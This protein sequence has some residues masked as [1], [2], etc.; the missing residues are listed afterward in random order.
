M[1]YNDEGNATSD[2]QPTYSQEI[3]VMNRPDGLYIR[4]HFTGLSDVRYEIAWPK[5]STKRSC[6][7]ND[8]IE[9]SRLNDNITAFVEGESDKQSI[10][11][12]IPKDK[13]MAHSALFENVF[14]K[15]DQSVV[16]S[17]LLHVTDEMGVGGSWVTGLEHIGMKKMDLVDYS[18]YMGNGILTDL[19][20]YEKELPVLYSGENLSVLGPNAALN[21]A[22]FKEADAALNSIDA[23][24]STIVIADNTN[25][26]NSGRFIVSELGETK[27]IADVFL[28]NSMH[29]QFSLSKEEPL[30]AEI[31]ASLLSH[32]AVGSEKSRKIVE[33]LNHELTSSELEEV[34]EMLHNQNGQTIDASFLD[35]VIGDVTGFKTTFISKNNDAEIDFYPFLLEDPREVMI[36]DKAISGASPIIK[37]GKPLYPATKIMQELGYKI[38]STNQSLYIE[39]TLRNFR[40]PLNELFYVYNER[41]YNLNSM[42]FERIGD[43]FYFEE[44]IFIRIFLVEVNK[45][46]EIIEVVPIAQ[47]TEVGGE[48]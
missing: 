13:A 45:T 29:A 2:V 8:G 7:L 12:V 48:K 33:V 40:F 36:A 35:D 38:S 22:D 14:A 30:M 42:P 1:H 46:A 47:F 9:C 16:D 5:I 25:R 18:L 41:R 37:E 27:D 39:N 17:T 10:T 20:W 31:I 26:V 6:Y 28:V 44:A 3:E 21:L 19:Y 11:Y 23:L 43:E 4:H 32:K 15:L 24:H 34:V